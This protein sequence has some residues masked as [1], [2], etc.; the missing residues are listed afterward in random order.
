MTNEL[1]SIADALVKPKL[2][3]LLDQ[4]LLPTKFLSK[5]TEEVC[6]W[7]CA[8]MFDYS[9]ARPYIWDEANYWSG[10]L[11]SCSF[12]AWIIEVFTCPQLNSSRL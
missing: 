12:D 2:C 4:E 1:Y 11:S 7:S 5:V 9:L 10:Y 6:S 3:S 8:D